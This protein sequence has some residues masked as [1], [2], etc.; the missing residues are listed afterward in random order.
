MKLKFLFLML[1]TLYT[2]PT[3]ASRLT[4]IVNA[5]KALQGTQI[6]M[7]AVQYDILD[8][9]HDI[10]GLMKQVN[11]NLTSHAGWGSY[12]VHDYQSYGNEAKNWESVIKMAGTNNSSGILGET[13]NHLSNEFP[14]DKKSFS[15]SN[16]VDN[17]QLY[18]AIKSQTA[19]ATRAASQLDYDKIAD[20][21]S[22]Q[23]MLLQQIDKAKDLKSAVDLSNRIQI[24]ANLISLSILRQ[25]AVNNQQQSITEQATINGALANAKFLTKEMR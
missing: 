12:N 22:Y 7:L 16:N 24:E 18:Y 17:Q 5:L 1:I 10:Q 4:N 8:S 14:I 25:T 9:Q 19:L 2:L 21:M 3:Q 15:R 23:K 11:N 6:S 20:Q 13:I